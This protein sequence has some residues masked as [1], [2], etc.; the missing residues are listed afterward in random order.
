MK[1]Y[2]LV[3]FKRKLHYGRTVHKKIYT[4]LTYLV[5]TRIKPEEV[6]YINKQ[7]ITDTFIEARSFVERC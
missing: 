4:K 3:L 6:R 7:T 2:D 5:L 1:S